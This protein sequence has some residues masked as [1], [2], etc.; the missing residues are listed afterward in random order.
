VHFRIF[1]RLA[2]VLNL[3]ADLLVAKVEV[4]TGLDLMVLRF[5][6]THLFA[7]AESADLGVAATVEALIL[8]VAEECLGQVEGAVVHGAAV[9][10]LMAVSA[11]EVYR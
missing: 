10:L 11:L 5:A 6:A 2:D 7:R 4:F 3:L 1:V 8:I 9:E